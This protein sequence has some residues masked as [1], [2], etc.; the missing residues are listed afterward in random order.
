[1]LGTNLE[2][3]LQ[4]TGAALIALQDPASPLVI[5][6]LKVIDRLWPNEQGGLG[7]AMALAAMRLNGQQRPN[8]AA[9]LQGLIDTTE[10]LDDGVALAWATIALGAGIAKLR[11]HA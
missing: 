3:Y 7:L 10:L 4:T 1:M 6:G 5:R 9:A 8:L 11:V 2:P